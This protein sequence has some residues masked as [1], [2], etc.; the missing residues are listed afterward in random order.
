MFRKRFLSNV[1]RKVY[2]NGQAHPASLSNSL[3][4]IG[5][6]EGLIIAEDDELGVASERY[7]NSLFTCAV[8]TG[9]IRIMRYLRQFDANE[10]EYAMRVSARRGYIK[11]M[12]WIAK[13]W[14]IRV[15]RYPA[16]LEACE[17]REAAIID[18]IIYDQPRSLL[19]FIRWGAEINCVHLNSAVSCRSLKVLKLMR[20]LHQRSLSIPIVTDLDLEQARRPVIEEMN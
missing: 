7:I 2:R 11:T 6:L 13:T 16:S 20:R 8:G 10:I 14:P 17:M 19:L 1:E 18:A 3:C 9:D 12:I 5:W 4:K 15:G